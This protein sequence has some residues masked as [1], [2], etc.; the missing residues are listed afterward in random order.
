MNIGDLV[1]STTAYLDDNIHVPQGTFGVVL[2]MILDYNEDEDEEDEDDEENG[3][4]LFLIGWLNEDGIAFE[5]TYDEVEVLSWFT[6]ICSGGVDWEEA[7]TFIDNWNNV[8][9]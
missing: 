8:E 2:A 1:K 6:E 4:I 9:E 5:V 3:E 7:M